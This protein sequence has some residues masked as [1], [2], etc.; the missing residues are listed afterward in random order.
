MP[1]PAGDL[2]E[3]EYDARMPIASSIPQE[4]LADDEEVDFRATPDPQ[5]KFSAER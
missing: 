2:A 4:I 1:R 3:Q 5:S